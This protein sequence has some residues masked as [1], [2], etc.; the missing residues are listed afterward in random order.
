MFVN[1]WNNRFS[2]KM[3]CDARLANK[4]PLFCLCVQCKKTPLSKEYDIDK[5]GCP[6]HRRFMA[7]TKYLELAAAIFACPEFEE[8]TNRISLIDH[9]YEPTQ[10]KLAEREE[11]SRYQFAKDWE[12][13]RKIWGINEDLKPV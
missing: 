2:R 12:A 7:A 5:D 11:E 9:L 3:W 8:D 6:I 10:E 1:I 13:Q 4:G